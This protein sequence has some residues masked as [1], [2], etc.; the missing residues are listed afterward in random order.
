MGLPSVSARSRAHSAPHRS[1]GSECPTGRHAGHS[2]CPP[3][4]NFLPG[5]GRRGPAHSV[6]SEGGNDRKEAIPGVVANRRPPALE[7]DHVVHAA[8]RT[9]PDCLVLWH[10]RL[11]AL[12]PLAFRRGRPP[13]APGIL[14]RGVVQGSLYPGQGQAGSPVGGQMHRGGARAGVFGM[15]SRPSPKRT[16]LPPASNAQ[17]PLFYPWCCSTAESAGPLW[18]GAHGQ[19]MA[20]IHGPSPLG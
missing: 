3:L 14:R 1:R 20:Q 4:P 7:C 16:A 15:M 19:Q 11:Q 5:R 12:P 17:P 2:P 6:G 8:V 18:V 13:P 9:G 10:R